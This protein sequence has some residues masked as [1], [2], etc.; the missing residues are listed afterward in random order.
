MTTDIIIINRNLRILDN[1]A[2]YYGSLRSNYIVVY[3]YDCPLFFAFLAFAQAD[4]GHAQTGHRKA[5]GR[6]VLGK[7]RLKM[8]SKI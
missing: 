6:M 4:P 2:L 3:L 8:Q 7:E 5:A 1:A